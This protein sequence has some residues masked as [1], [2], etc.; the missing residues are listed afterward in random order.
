[1]RD[2][3]SAYL[4]EVRQKTDISRGNEADFR[5]NQSKHEGQA[6]IRFRR[7]GHAMKTSA[8]VL[9]AAA[10]WMAGCTPSYRVHVN[11][12]AD[13]NRPVPQGTPVYVTEDPNAG[14]PILRKQ[15]ASKIGGLLQSYGH[16][17]TQTADRADYLL[18]FEVGFHSSQVVDFTPMYRP[19]G[20]FGSRFSRGGFGY[21]TYVPY[22][23]TVYVHWLRMKL[24]AKDGAALSQANVVWLGEAVAGANDPE[25][26][27]A[28]NYL[29]V[30]CI[31]YFGVDTREW[32]T[33]PIKRDDPR[34]LGIAEEP[35]EET[36]R[37]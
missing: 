13:P 25:L 34:I 35:P 23:D 15:I 14:N 11:T 31:E 3:R 22:V 9:T 33:M 16:N 37:R 17:P 8:M 30:A 12:F 18:T 36:N 4:T 5:V 24:Y 10:A 19:F 20:G 21:T 26:R 1:M 28:V 2:A 6:R 32:V 7:K 27:Q 29:L